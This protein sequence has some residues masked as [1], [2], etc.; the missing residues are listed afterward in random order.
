MKLNVLE[1]ITLLGLL[2]TEGTYITFKLL[3]DLKGALAFNEK[4]IKE[5]CIKENDGRITWTKS[6]DKEVDIGDTIKEVIVKKLKELDS[7]GKI[8]DQNIGLFE[9][10]VN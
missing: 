7:Q 6:V 9:K 10:F 3:I 5:F 4:E 2:P 1:R 8:N